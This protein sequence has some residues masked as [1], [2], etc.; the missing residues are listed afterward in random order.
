[1]SSPIHRH[2]VDAVVGNCGDRTDRCEA[3]AAGDD[4]LKQA[5]HLCRARPL[6]DNQNDGPK[7]DSAHRS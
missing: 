5:L 2:P 6:A 3:E 1:M 4:H 7:A